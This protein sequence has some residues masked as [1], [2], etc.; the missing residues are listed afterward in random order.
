MCSYA[1]APAAA[2]TSRQSARLRKLR[3]L[4]PARTVAIGTRLGQLRRDGAKADRARLIRHAAR[5]RKKKLRA[6]VIVKGNGS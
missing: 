1:L 5:V 2:D 4:Q 6:I 3:L